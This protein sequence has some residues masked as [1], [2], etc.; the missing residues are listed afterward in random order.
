M[1]F[2]LTAGSKS[3]FSCSYRLG[4]LNLYTD[5]GWQERYVDDCQVIYKGYVDAFDLGTNLR[6][7]ISQDRPKFSGNF[8][9]ICH[10]LSSG[11]ISFKNDLWRGFPIY[12]NDDEITNLN[13]GTRVAWTDSV[14]VLDQNFQIQEQKFDLIGP[15]ETHPITI[16]AA[17]HKIQQILLDKT[18]SFLSHNQLP[19]RV[20]LSGGVDSLLSYCL[21]RH[22][23]A[24]VELVRCSHFDYDPFWLLNDSQIKENFWGYTQ[25]HHWTEPCVLTSGAPGDE[26]MLRSPTTIDMLLKYR[27]LDT[28]AIISQQQHCLHYDYFTR[29]KHI[30]LFRNQ[31]IDVDV[32]IEQF[33]WTLCN[34]VAND[35]QHWHIGHTLTWTPL[36]DLEIFKIFLRLPSTYCLDQMFDSKLSIN[37]IERLVPGSSD[38]LSD[39]KN[40]HN[41]MKNLL[42]LLF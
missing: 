16:D 41:P 15:I 40:S 22:L 13:P 38:V 23:D 6:A 32:P 21:L 25:I 34:I 12:L 42:R 5:Q 10:D 8:C 29:D 26:F 20:H 7:I 18:R 3:N 31:K 24:K 37:L 30:D 28:L 19:I 2:S 4:E 35:W 39:Q 9:A 11:Q 33:Y 36:R 1:F 27:G 14:I 17:E